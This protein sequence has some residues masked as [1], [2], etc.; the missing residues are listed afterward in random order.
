MQY[1]LSQMC[2][3]TNTIVWVPIDII[4]DFAQIPHENALCAFLTRAD[5]CLVP[6][7]HKEYWRRLHKVYVRVNKR[8]K[9][10]RYISSVHEHPPMFYLFKHTSSTEKYPMIYQK[11]TQLLYPV[12]G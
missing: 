7:I 11:C 5:N 10:M 6:I 1:L 2:P 4:M 12:V 9:D 8:K 3:Q